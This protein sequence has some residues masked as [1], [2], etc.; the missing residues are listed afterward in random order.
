[1]KK[2]IFKIILLLLIPAGSLFAQ[3]Q[4]SAKLPEKVTPDNWHLLD[5]EGTG[6]YGISLDKA[7]ELLKGKKSQQVLVAVIDSGIDTLH[8]DLKP[9]LWKNTKEIPGNGKDDDKN[10]YN[11]DYYGWNFL[12]GKDGRNVK[13]DSYEAARVYWKLKDKYSGG[14]PDTTQ[15]TGTDKFIASEYLRAKK[16][17][18]DDVDAFETQITKRVLGVLEAGDSVIARRLGKEKFNGHD[19]Q[20]YIPEGSEDKA[21]VQIY[22]QIQRLN[23]SDDITN[24]DILGSIRGEVKK[25]EAASTPPEDYRGEIVGD[26][27]DDINDR[28][29]GNSDVMAGTPSHGT[30]CSGI[31]GAVR[32]NGIGMDG[33]ADNVRVMML[34]AVPDGDEHDKDIALAIRYAVDNGAKIISMSFGKSFSP[35][36]SWVDDA[37]KYAAEHDVLL[38]HAAGN[39]SKNLDSSFNF[40]NPVFADGSGEAKN[41]ITVGANGDPTN[42]GFTAKF[43]NYGKNS[44]DVFAPGVNIYSTLPGGNVYGKMSGTSMAAPVVSGI[45]A[46]L[47]EYFP[48]LSAEQL[49]Y[50]IEKSVTPITEDVILP[51]TQGDNPVMVKLSDI[52]KTGGEVNAYNA[53]KLAMT[54]K[55]KRKGK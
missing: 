39:S 26:N 49:K 46:L 42:G 31:I 51:G 30:H 48:K 53:V 18:V 15:L 17:V 33:I 25:A 36:K 10:G 52:S 16:E 3:E 45:A 55:G 43:S 11:D 20:E 6:Y 12:G 44:V 32:N 1:M 8:E 35:Q 54:I 40:P 4:D 13:T 23:N 22:R 27:Y 19:L 28:Y 38:V 37:V 14:D 34:R 50:V 29:Y 41:F 7:Y 9:V 24:E 5:R 2:I 47:L 21:A